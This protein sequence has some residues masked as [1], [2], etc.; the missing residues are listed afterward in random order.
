MTDS[1]NSTSLNDSNANGEE[2]HYW[3]AQLEEGLSQPLHSNKFGRSNSWS[4]FAII[5]GTNFTDIFD[6]SFKQFSLQLTM[7]I[8]KLLMELLIV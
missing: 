1:S 2:I 8:L 3:G 6:T 7:I 4:D 5:K